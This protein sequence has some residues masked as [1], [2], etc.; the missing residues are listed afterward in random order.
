M[1]ARLYYILCP[2][3]WLKTPPLGLSYL[4]A[5]GRKQGYEVTVIDLNAILYRQLGNTARAWLPLDKEFEETLFS[6]ARNTAPQC[7]DDL[8]KKIA[9][10]DLIG[11][12]LFRRNAPFT[13]QLIDYLRGFYPD[14][15]IVLGGPETTWMKLRRQ[16]F[17]DEFSWVI[18]EGEL[19]APLILQSKKPLKI[20]NRELADLDD[21]PFLDL[22]EYR[23]L[24]HISTLPLLSSR[25]CIRKCSFCTE[26]LLC[27]SFRQHSPQYMIEQ[28]SLLKSRYN[29]RYFTFQDSLINGSLA[30][31]EKFT[32]LLIKHNLDISWEAQ[33]AVRKD[34]DRD[35]ARRIK[36]SGCFNLFIGAESA[37]DQ[38]LSLMNKGY[39][40][41][42]LFSFLSCLQT[43][44]LNYEI[45][46]IAGYPGEKESDFQETIDF[47]SCHKK[48]VSKIAQ[49]NPYIDYFDPDHTVSCTAGQRAQKLIDLLD[50]EHIRYTKSFINNLVYHGND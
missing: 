12:S 26:R 50:R 25:G 3:H 4:A 8:R 30:W 44:G 29:I 28:I 27:S 47:L 48:L 1:K 40:R 32:G 16:K 19:S 24:S 21:I 5:Y 17:S 36:R 35:L 41:K 11:F 6:R 18:G 45:S 2:P 7:L 31:L 14:K 33:I 37:S 23:S 46:L 13:F 20:E 22:S 34:L 10:A 49:I 15:K 43:A 42:E 38:V 9:D 39:S